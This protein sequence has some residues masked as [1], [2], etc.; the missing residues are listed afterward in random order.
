MKSGR[1]RTSELL[2]MHRSLEEGCFSWLVWVFSYLSAHYSSLWVSVSGGG[3]QKW[4]A[5]LQL[6]AELVYTTHLPSVCLT[7]NILR[8]Q[9]TLSQ[10]FKVPQGRL[11]C[12]FLFVCFFFKIQENRVPNNSRPFS[13][14]PHKYFFQII[15]VSQCLVLFFA[16]SCLTAIL[17]TTLMNFGML[18]P[19]RGFGEGRKWKR[20]NPHLPCI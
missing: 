9:K 16:P 6:S 11:C 1:P 13:M 14:F 5:S 10:V 12:V 17:I 3:R 4:I 19:P 18:L 20:V 15:L 8:M 2:P 7:Q